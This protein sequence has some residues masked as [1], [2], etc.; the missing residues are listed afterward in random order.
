ME[1]MGWSAEL[2]LTGHS[3]GAGV[4]ALLGIMWANPG[5]CRTSSKSGLPAGR[6]VKVYGFA[7]PCTTDLCL[8]KLW[9]VA[10]L[11]GVSAGADAKV[12]YCHSKNLVHSFVFSSDAV[13]RFSLGHIRVR[14]LPRRSKRSAD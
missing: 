5:S 8:S 7:P 4:A 13:A 12:S 9:C 14:A 11:A 6:E 2:C 10:L 3:L 1:L